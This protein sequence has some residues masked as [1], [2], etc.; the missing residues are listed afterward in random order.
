MKARLLFLCG[1]ILAILLFGATV[2][3][4]QSSA[5]CPV[6][7]LFNAWAAATPAGA[8][9]GVI[10][11]LL[12]N[13]SDEDD[14]L[15]S[16]STDAAEGVEFHQTVMGANDVM[17]M[18]PVEGGIQVAANSYQVLKS[19]GYH[20]MLV[21][22]KK[23]LVVGDSLSLTLNFEHSAAV[24]INLPVKNIVEAGNSM[25]DMNSGMVMGATSTPDSMGAMP[26]T[27]TTTP[28]APMVMW[29]TACV[30]MHVVGGWARP[31]GPGMP[32]SAAYGLLVNLTDA[33]DTLLSASTSAASAVEL[34]DMM[35]SSGDVMQMNPIEGGVVIPADDAVLFEPGGKH[36]MLVGLTQELA[37]GTTID[38]TLSFAQSGELRVSLPI[39][40]QTDSAM[41]VDAM[42]D[43]NS[44]S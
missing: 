40:D 33:D 31:A 3:S 7:T 24:T 15:V 30:G 44:G 26:M 6:V 1:S 39:Q 9:N 5:N 23:A 16:A 12:T 4:A 35:I 27:G 41:P 18:Q 20:I 28:S 36:M 8:P 22:L 14:R 17:Q 25:G 11:G 13:L 32:N 38:L 34:H 29:P 2:A 19:G 42:P 37:S 10:Y 43:G 21:N